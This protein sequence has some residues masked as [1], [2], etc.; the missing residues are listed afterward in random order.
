MEICVPLII[1]GE[2]LTA[3]LTQFQASRPL[4]ASLGEAVNVARDGAPAIT[5]GALDAA[6]MAFH[7]RRFITKPLGRAINVAREE[8]PAIAGEELASFIREFHARP[9]ETLS[10]GTMV[11]VAREGVPALTGQELM[12]ALARFHTRPFATISLG[13]IDLDTDTLPGIDSAA[14]GL[15]AAGKPPAS[16]ASDEPLFAG[17]GSKPVP[18]VI[19]ERQ[20]SLSSGLVVNP[21]ALAHLG[22]E[23]GPENAVERMR[24][25]MIDALTTK[26]LDND[27]KPG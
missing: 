3:A 22:Y 23:T 1:R 16:S 8:A 4:T 10:L 17:D 19:G 18:F 26:T 21:L 6:V 7:A 27:V 11:N 12:E 20:F 9:H 5:G 24:V 14:H 25:L 15:A 13:A 2:A